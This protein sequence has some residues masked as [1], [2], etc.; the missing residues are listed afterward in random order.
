MKSWSFLAGIVLAS[1]LALRGDGAIVSYSGTLT[2]PA[3]SP[4]NASPGTGSTTVVYDSV[5]HTLAV[6]VSFSGLTATTTAAHIHSATAIAGTGTAG[7]A[8]TTPSFTGFPLGVTAG[9]MSN[10][11]DL[12]LSSSWNPAFV[13][14]N[15]G[16]T[17]TAESALAAGLAAGRAYLN[18]HTSTFGG[19]EIRS[20]LLP[21]SPVTLV[22]F[23]AE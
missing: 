21:T 22:R 2:G 18:I 19:G 17:A 14:A 12:T 16:T 7:V 15:G 13:T 4:P 5:A 23:T 6:D 9:S 20:F 11:Y 1:L 3:E 10:T 8:T